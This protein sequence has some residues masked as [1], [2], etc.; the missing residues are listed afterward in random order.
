MCSSDLVPEVSGTGAVRQRGEALSRR[1]TGGRTAIGIVP[2][3]LGR[4]RKSWEKQ[5]EIILPQCNFVRFLSKL[6][7]FLLKFSQNVHRQL[8]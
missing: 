7:D 6:T 5:R 8:F 1:G 2:R 3:S 4:F